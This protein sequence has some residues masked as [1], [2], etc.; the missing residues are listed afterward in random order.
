[1]RGMYSPEIG[2]VKLGERNAAERGHATSFLNCDWGGAHSGMLVCWPGSVQGISIGLLSE[3][4]HWICCLVSSFLRTEGDNLS[5][6][7]SPSSGLHPCSIVLVQGK[8]FWRCVCT[9]SMS[10]P[11]RARVVQHAWSI[12]DH[13]GN[14]HPDTKKNM[15]NF[16]TMFLPLAVRSFGH[17]SDSSDCW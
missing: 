10:L 13:E 4:A 5:D 7:P 6:L 14:K 11:E 8:L 12:V 15:D 17:V 2:Y 1:M 9:R 16:S 3:S